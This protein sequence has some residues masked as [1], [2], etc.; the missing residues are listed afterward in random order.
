MKH[1]G[2]HNPWNLILVIFVPFLMVLGGCE[3]AIRVDA[4]EVLQPEILPA[5]LAVNTS[6]NATISCPTSDS[7]IRYTLDGST[8]TEASS[9]Y[10]SSIPISDDTT[11]KARAYK[12]G[13]LASSVADRSYRFV[14]RATTMESTPDSRSGYAAALDGTTLYVCGGMSGMTVLDTAYKLDLTT[15]TWTQ[16]A[17]LPSARDTAVAA[18]IGGYLYLIGGRD[19]TFTG[20][21][22]CYRYD[23][24]SNS[25]D[26]RAAMPTARSGSVSAIIDEKIFVAGGAGSSF[27]SK[28]ERYDPGTNTWTALSDMPL[29]RQ[30]SHGGGSGTHF[31][32]AGGYNSFGDGVWDDVYGYSVA[33]NTWT[34]SPPSIGCLPSLP[35]RRVNAAGVFHA[36]SFYVMG[37]ADAMGGTAPVYDTV[38]SYTPGASAWAT[39]FPMPSSTRLGGAFSMVDRILVLSPTKVWYYFPTKE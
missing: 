37:G 25:W 8:P 39:R 11:L 38:F 21:S 16:I 36:G 7:V 10:T 32:L 33:S 15:G 34:P 5:T 22:S 20:V 23:I 31:Y 35:G 26:T 19:A 3:Q 27:S 24:S 30:Y 12:S 4:E 29:A 17:D 18:V 6:F 13:Y 1:P 28:L 14:W 2:L 9:I